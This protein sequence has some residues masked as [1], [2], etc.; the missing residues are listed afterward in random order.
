MLTSPAHLFWAQALSNLIQPRPPA[1]LSNG[2]VHLR[3]ESTR[4]LLLSYLREA[5]KRTSPHWLLRSAFL[6]R[7]SQ[8]VVQEARKED[9]SPLSL[10]KLHT[11]PLKRKIDDLGVY[12]PNQAEG[13]KV[14]TKVGELNAHKNECGF[15]NVV[16]TQG[17]GRLI[18]HKYLAEH[19]SKFCP[20][21]MMTCAYCGKFKRSMVNT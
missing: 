17:C 20:K 4:W 8:A 9:L 16:C 11:L 2:G 7:L 3:Q 12:C 13:C 21:R 15:A 18:Y 19:C 10:W 1:S 14:I 6:P 5:V